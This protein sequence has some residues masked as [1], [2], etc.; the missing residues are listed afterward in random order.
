MCFRR[1]YESP[2][3]TAFF[4]LSL[5]LL[6]GAASPLPKNEIID[7][8][9]HVINLHAYVTNQYSAGVKNSGKSVTEILINENHMK[10]F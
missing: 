10:L 1:R 7:I 2:A 9:S 3:L 6:L 8:R 4:V 5:Y